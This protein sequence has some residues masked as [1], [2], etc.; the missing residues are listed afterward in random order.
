MTAKDEKSHIDVG[1]EAIQTLVGQ[2]FDAPKDRAK[3]KRTFSEN[4]AGNDDGNDKG[5]NIKSIR[6]K[7]RRILKNKKRRNLPTS[8]NTMT[9]IYLRKQ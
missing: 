1:E 3:A 7:V 8:K 9:E 4:N 2:V 6:D 5:K